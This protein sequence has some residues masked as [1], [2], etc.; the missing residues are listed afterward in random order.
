MSP[1]TTFGSGDSSSNLDQADFCGGPATDSSFDCFHPVDTSQRCPMSS[2]VS[3]GLPSSGKPQNEAIVESTCRVVHQGMDKV[4]FGGTIEESI[5]IRISV[6]RAEKL[7]DNR[8]RG[9]NT[10][11]ARIRTLSSRAMSIV[12]CLLLPFFVLL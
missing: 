11:A 4:A 12:E 10:V 6:G 8:Q 7:R 1:A 2:S 9:S 5:F 3:C